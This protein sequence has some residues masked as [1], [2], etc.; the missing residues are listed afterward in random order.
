MIYFCGVYLVIAY[1]YL[2]LSIK[3]YTKVKY[4]ILDSLKYVDIYT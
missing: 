1:V 3:S 2:Y 4:N